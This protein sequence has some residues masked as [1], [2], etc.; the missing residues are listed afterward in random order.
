MNSRLH[1]VM[2][3]IIPTRDS[4]RGKKNDEPVMA[5][6]MMAASALKERFNSDGTV[7]FYMRSDVPK[8]H[9]PR[10]H[11]DYDGSDTL[12]R[13]MW[14]FSRNVNIGIDKRV[15]FIDMTIRF[16]TLCVSK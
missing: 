2:E 13:H 7:K 14:K 15:F 1:S 12:D 16:A 5:Q 11:P 6:R 4:R 3:S 9:L 10:S 8:A